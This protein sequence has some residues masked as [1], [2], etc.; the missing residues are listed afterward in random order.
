MASDRVITISGLGSVVG[1]GDEG[2]VSVSVCCDGD[3][4]DRSGEVVRSVGGSITALADGEE[5]GTAFGSRSRTR[6]L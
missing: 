4:V 1:G 3:F 2:D 5:G 6:S